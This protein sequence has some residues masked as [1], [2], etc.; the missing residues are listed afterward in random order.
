MW[1]K[2]TA[3]LTACT[4][5]PSYVGT[6]PPEYKKQPTPDWL[7]KLKNFA[8]T[9]DD[10]SKI[11]IKNPTAGVCPGIRSFL[12]DPITIN[13]WADMEIRVFPDGTW[14]HYTRPMWGVSVVE[15]NKEQFGEAYNKRLSLKLE[16]PW[17]FVCDQPIK[18]MFMESHYSTSYFRDNNV[19]FPP[20]IIEYKYQ[21]S[22]NVHLSVP[23]PENEPYI[24][25]LRH[26]QPLVSLFP[27]TETPINFDVK[28]VSR[29][30]YGLQ[31]DIMPKMF[32]GRYFKQPGMKSK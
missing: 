7:K 19:L 10:R 32:I 18:F 12:N 8:I 9:W 27:M 30:E 20:G 5:D 17:H 29:D 15:H 22:T 31:S 26:G 24:I 2:K 14:T 28:L 21:H 1:F 25:S 23:I 6:C 16:S 13:M 3:N 4:F 11:A